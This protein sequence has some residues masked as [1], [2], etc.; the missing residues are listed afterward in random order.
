MSA[1]ITRL[2][3]GLA[4]VVSRLGTRSDKARWDTYVAYDAPAEEIDAAFRTTWLRKICEIPALDATREWRAWQAEDAQI[5]AIEKEENRLGLRTKLCEA[6]TWA[7]KDGGAII[8]MGGLPGL[9]SSPVNIEAVKIGDLKYLTVIERDQISPGERDSDVLSANYGLPMKYTVG[10]TD[11]HP[12]RVIRLS[13]NKISNFRQWNAGWSDPIW[14]AV[15]DGVKNS[16]LIAA[17]VASLVH[18]A[19]V[20]IVKIKGLGERLGTQAYEDLLIQRFTSTNT[21]KSLVNALILDGEDEWDQKALNFAGFPDIQDRALMTMCGLADIPATRLLGRSPQGLNATGDSDLKNYYDMVRSRQ[22]MELTPA[23]HPMDEIL[24]R[25][26]LGSRPPEIYYEWNPL[27]QMSATESATVEKTFADALTAR[28][29][30]GAIDERVLAKAELNRMVESGQYPGIEAAIAESAQ[31]DAVYDPEEQEAKEIER[32]NME[33]EIAAR[34]RPKFVAA[35][36]AAPRSLYIRRDVLNA[37]E[38]ARWAKGQGFTDIVP[39]LHVTIAYSRAEV[40]WF[41]VGQSWSAKL[42]IPAGGPRQMDAMGPEK[43]YLALLF[44]AN[45]LIW[46]NRE[47]RE[48]GASWDWPEYQPHITIQIG[49]S[50]DLA[51]VDPYQGKIVL[52]PEIFEEVR[53][54]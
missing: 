27:W 22:E 46:R 34:N 10:S 47:I 18:E 40:D 33:A 3:D 5:E 50:V 53:G 23:L 43:N 31:D 30:T 42:E 36:D 11:I 20:D 25:S 15:R 37:A 39:D 12:S 1:V 44:T 21:L 28:I 4:N 2:R 16:D 41:A 32:M 9:P 29:N 8:L 7:R 51:K 48:A 35:N 45:E 19:K 49:G 17:A 24:I 54:E 26:A 14:L 13:G 38:I 52:G 6:L